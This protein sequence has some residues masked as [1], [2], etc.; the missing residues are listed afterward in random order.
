MLC[1]ISGEAPQQPVASRKSGN[2]FERRLIESYI[3]EN[4]TDPVTGEDLTVEDLVELKQARVVRP[5][6]PT[7]T[8]IPAL[9]STFQNEWDAL[10]LETYQLKQQLAETRQELS[11]ALYYSDS[12]EKVIARLQQERDEAR[13]ALAKISVTSTS[14]GAN[15]DAMQVDGQGLPE[16]IV[17]KIEQTQAELSS[18][19][20]KRPTPEGW[21]TPD[22]LQSMQSTQNSEPLYPG[23]RSIAVDATGDLALVGGNDGV[24]GVYSVSQGQVIQTLKCGGGS[25]TDAVWSG[26]K[27]V[28]ALSTGAVKMFDNGAEAASFDRHAGAANALALHPC[29]DIL[30]SVGVDKSYVLYDL[31]SLQPITQ[32]STDSELTTAAFHP[33]GHLFAAG[34]SKGAIKLFDVKTSENVANFDSTFGQSPLQ[35]VSFSENGTWLASAVQGQTSVSVWDLRKMAEIKTIDLGTAVTGVSWDYTGQYLAACGQGFVAVEHYSKS[36]KSWSEPFRKALNAV[37]VKWGV[38]AQSLVA[39]ATDGS[40]LLLLLVNRERLVEPLSFTFALSALTRCQPRSMDGGRRRPPFDF[41][42]DRSDSNKHSYT[43]MD[44]RHRSSPS[45]LFV[46]QESDSPE[47]RTTPPR[48]PLLALPS[49]RSHFPRDGFDYRRPLSAAQSST[50][51]NNVID[52]TSDDDSALPET[53][54]TPQPQFAAAPM[55]LP[56][57]GRE[58]I[59]L[60]A[61]TSPVRPA[62]PRHARTSPSPEVQFVSSR[63]LSRTDQHPP[64][65]PPFLD[66]HPERRRPVADLILDDDDDV[67]VAGSRTGVNLPRP[68]EAQRRPQLGRLAHLMNELP[69][70]RAAAMAAVAR[71]RGAMP[72][73][74]GA[75]EDTDF[76]RPDARLFTGMM[77]AFLNY[78]TV[79][80]NVGTGDEDIQ[81]PLPKFDPPPP[82]PE[83]FTRDPTEEDTIVCPNCEEE[84]AVGESEEKRQVWVVKGCGHVYCGTCMNNRKRRV[85]KGAKG[86]GRADDPM[87]PKPFVNCR[88]DNCAVRVSHKNDVM[89]IFL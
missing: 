81:L 4:G 22:S 32:V 53:A 48:H 17:A 5:R 76:S 30:A 12:A 18:T 60:S 57:F 50:S 80:F 19:R 10:I 58:I 31:Q 84:L 29:G 63:P 6:P 15:G 51:A 41:Q 27:P 64:N 56:R 35:T 36:A 69:T 33:D 88:A 73:I 74:F 87:L 65:P 55:A 54:P 49:I 9:L 72:S 14:N 3:S 38:K 68:F 1:A 16:A 40:N 20:R 77:P 52:L 85:L 61:E 86:K 89:Q 23:G 82:A 2:V 47:R 25:V 83:G 70:L 44:P 43:Q 39:L 59:D 34:S 26:N 28:I 66:P 78:E 79:A 42:F 8:S 71:G 45:P 62:H 24:V 7:L 46:R 11:T 37:D 13:D 21:A 75:T 67:I